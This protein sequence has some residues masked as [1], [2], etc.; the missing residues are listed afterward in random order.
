VKGVESR[1]ER[2]FTK[3]RQVRARSRFSVSDA[4]IGLK[5]GLTLCKERKHWQSKSEPSTDT[6][7]WRGRLAENGPS[8]S[9]GGFHQPT[10]KNEAGDR[11]PLDGAWK[12][13]LV[14]ASVQGCDV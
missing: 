8:L 13:E 4:R 12:M 2:R 3:V 5:S 10:S 1:S 9:V 14:T 11:G 7:S 6:H